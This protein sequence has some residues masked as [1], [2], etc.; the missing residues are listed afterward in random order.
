MKAKSDCAVTYAP[1]PAPLEVRVESS[2]RVLFGRAIEE[3]ARRVAAAC[4]VTTGLLAIDDAG[5]L[6]HV[7]A[8]RVEA[9]L[10]AAGSGAPAR[11]DVRLQP[12]ARDRQRRT[13]LYL[14]GNQPDFVPNAALFGA[15]CLILDLEDSV[16]PDRKAEAR[17]LVRRTLEAHPEFFSGAE[18]AVRINPL[19]GPFG[20]A[21]LAELARC[22]PQ[23]V[24]LPKCEAPA[25]VL[26][27]ARELDALEPAAGRA[28]GSTLVLPLVETARGVLAA[29]AIA[30]ASPRVAALLFGAE[31]FAADIGARR[32]KEGTESLF[33][34]QS[35]VVAAAAAGVQALDSVFSDT[36]DDAGLASYCAASRAMGF[37]GVGILHPR[38]VGPAVAAFSPTEEELAEAREIVA[39]LEEAERAGSGVASLHGKMI[40]APVARRARRLLG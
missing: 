19:A 11:S 25:D 4:G 28:P 7:A 37:A 30:A 14:P 38:Q 18:L 13:R 32:T 5:A 31:D 40:D 1:G 35:V 9:A 6:D 3:A 26:A 24:I 27:L 17:V 20:A 39:A 29:P 23:A 10:R 33:A 22:L 12:G 8:A 36:E 16:A 34:R 2:V 21:D 15:D